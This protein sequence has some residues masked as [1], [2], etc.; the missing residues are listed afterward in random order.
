MT[1]VAQ[2]L[3][4]R[5]REDNRSAKRCGMISH[6]ARLCEAQQREKFKMSQFNLRV[7]GPAKLLRVT[8]THSVPWPADFSTAFR[9]FAGSSPHVDGYST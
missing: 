1:F 7:F 6:G 3:R 5:R 2:Y 4:S 8:D 9:K